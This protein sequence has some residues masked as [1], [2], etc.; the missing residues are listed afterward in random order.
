MSRTIR[1]ATT[2]QSKRMAHQ[3][4]LSQSHEAYVKDKPRQKKSTM[5]IPLLIV[6]LN[7]NGTDD[8]EDDQ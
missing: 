5:V 6:K 4:W 1:S 7:E 3:S 2:S 8:C